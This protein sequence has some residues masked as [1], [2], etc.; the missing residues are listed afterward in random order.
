ML[1]LLTASKDTKKGR[2]LQMLNN[3][4]KKIM[5]S[6]TKKVPYHL[7]KHVIAVW[8]MATKGMSFSD[9]LSIY[10]RNSD[11]IDLSSKDRKLLS[12]V[13]ITDVRKVWL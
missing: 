8:R 12:E 13:K 6:K 9:A 1:S 5:A 4:N 7:A 3:Q 10:L 2:E 11:M